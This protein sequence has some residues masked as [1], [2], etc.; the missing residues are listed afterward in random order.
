MLACNGRVRK[1]GKVS[2]TE[3]EGERQSKSGRRKG[4]TRLSEGA[5]LGRGRKMKGG[6]GIEKE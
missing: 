6:G 2:P 1:S 4:Q 3:G 5:E